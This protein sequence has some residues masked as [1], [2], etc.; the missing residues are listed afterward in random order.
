M[1]EVGQYVFW[2]PKGWG[3]VKSCDSTDYSIEV[4]F[5]DGC[6]ENFTKEGKYYD[7][8][9][10][11]S[12]FDSVDSMIEYFKQNDPPKPKRKV[13]KTFEGWAAINKEEKVWGIYTSKK[14]AESQAD[15]NEYFNIVVKLTGEYEVEE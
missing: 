10:F 5:N 12:L 6:E 15:C 9:D 4:R 1:F 2:P 11:V 8:D 13:K 14:A 3:I 7:Y